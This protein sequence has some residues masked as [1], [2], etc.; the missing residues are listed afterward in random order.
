[1]YKEVVGRALWAERKGRRMRTS[2][3]VL[4]FIRT[5]KTGPPTSSNNGRKHCGSLSG[6]AIVINRANSFID[7]I[8]L[9]SN[10][11]SVQLPEESRGWG[12]G[13]CLGNTKSTL[14]SREVP[15]GT[16]V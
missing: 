8:R 14:I 12:W 9:K 7:K 1:M 10:G 4:Q 16:Q 15:L 3:S 11:A 6:L 2:L 13:L 5:S